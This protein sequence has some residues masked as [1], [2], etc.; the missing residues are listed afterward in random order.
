MVKKTYS[1][2]EIRFVKFAEDEIITASSSATKDDDEP[3]TLPFVP[4]P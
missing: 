1:D 4:A 2:P 3:I